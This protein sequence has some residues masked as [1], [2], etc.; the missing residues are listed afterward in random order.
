VGK[1]TLARKS[2]IVEAVEAILDESQM[3]LV[4]DYKGLSVHEMNQLRNQLQP[5]NSTC[6]V[7]KNTLM[8]RAIADKENWA[9]MAEFL[10]GQ[11]AFILCKGDVSA[12]IKAYLDFQKKAKKSEFRGAVMEGQVLSADQAKAIAELP[13]KEVLIAQIAGGINALTTKIAVAIKEVPTSLG[14]AIKAVSENEDKAA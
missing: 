1:Q 12:A 11:A 14:R 7:I 4:F 6:M 13:P 8:N 10:S 5:T 2:E 9:G 3:V